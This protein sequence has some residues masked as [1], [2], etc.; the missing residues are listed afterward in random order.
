MPPIAATTKPIAVASR[1]SEAA[2][3][4][5]S[6]A[7]AICDERSRVVEQRLALDERLHEPRC[8][9]PTEHGGGSKCVGGSHDRTES[10]GGRYAERW[11]QRLRYGCDNEDRHD[12]QAQGAGV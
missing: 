2:S 11:N 6:D 1:R 10:E 8:A 4:N 12:H 5:R 9:Q 3:R 7:G